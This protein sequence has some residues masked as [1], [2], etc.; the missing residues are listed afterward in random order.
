LPADAAT[1]T[2]AAAAFMNATSTGVKISVVLPPIEKLI[3]STPSATA[4]SM[5]AT[6]SLLKQPAVSSVRPQ[7][8]L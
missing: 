2:P 6:E 1:N 4:W 3:T 5:A 7:Q 8:T